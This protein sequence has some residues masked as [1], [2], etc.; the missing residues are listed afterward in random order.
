M[1]MY[2]NR[3]MNMDVI[4]AATRLSQNR[5]IE[6]PESRAAKRAWYALSLARYAQKRRTE[7]GLNVPEAAGLSGLE[8]S[9]WDALEAGWV[10]ED[11]NLLGAIAGTLYAEHTLISFLA[12]VA[13]GDRERA[14]S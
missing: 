9:Q 3:F 10:P 2:R 14:A 13:R 4:E 8:L 5:P 11:E 12:L 7:L 1:S 6:T